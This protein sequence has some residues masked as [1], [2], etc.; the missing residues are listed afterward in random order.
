[1]MSRLVTAGVGTADRPRYAMQSRPGPP[2]GRREAVETAMRRSPHAPEVLRAFGV[3]TCCG[4][5]LTLAQ[6]A[7]SA[8]VPAE[9]L[10]RA[11]EE[12]GEGR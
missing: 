12:G 5:T 6:V 2:E 10:V 11:L 8:G 7:A 1:M 3:D 9:R 4:R